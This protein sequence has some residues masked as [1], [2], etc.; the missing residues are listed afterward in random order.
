MTVW[1]PY[2]RCGINKLESIQ[3]HAARFVMSDYHRTSSVTEM[4]NTLNWTSIELRNKELCLLT[5]YKLSMMCEFVTTGLYPLLLT[6]YKGQPLKVHS[7]TIIDAYKFS[8]YPHVFQQWNSLPDEIVSAQSIDLFR[9][10]LLNFT[11]L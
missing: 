9:L 4:I 11:N 6:S 5:F 8:F 7:A 10:K 2:T 3:R 1:A